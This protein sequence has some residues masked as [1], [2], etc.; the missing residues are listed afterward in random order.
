MRVGPTGNP[1]YEAKWRHAGRQRLRR[2]GP[3]WLQP[4]GAGGWHRRKG[5]VPD[6]HFD[7]K[8]ATVRMAEMVR[9]DAERLARDAQD[10]RAKR[11]RP[12]TLR[13]V[14]REW[15]V[16]LE[17]V[18]A[19]RPSTLRDYRSTLAEPGSPHRRGNGTT[20]GRLMAAFGDMPISDITTTDISQFLRSLDKVLASP[21]T[22]NKHRQVLSAIFN[23]ARRED[24]YR[25][26]VNPVTPTDK[27]RELPAA[28]LDFYEPDEVEQLAEAAAR[29]AYRKDAVG[30]GGKLMELGPDEI[31]ARAEEDAQD[32]ELFRVLAYT[33]LRLGEALALQWGDVDFTGRRLIV[34]AQS[35]ALSRDPRRVG[36]SCTYRSLIPRETR[37]SGYSRA[38]TSRSARTTSSAA[39]SV[40]AWMGRRCGG[41]TTPHGRRLAYGI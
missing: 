23:Y 40:P 21:R 22:V 33:G 20:S 10:D 2:V 5:R 41:A 32:G 28:A 30:R 39:V 36:R 12:P 17:E 18:R 37:C 9:E 14:A 13:L 11:E 27:R 24:T 25:L 29:G 34:N 31:L 7:E 1:F 19:A 3:A 4:D 38:A 35:R 16:W 8:Q 15:L 26:A 6:D